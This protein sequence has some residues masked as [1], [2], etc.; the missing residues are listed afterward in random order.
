MGTKIIKYVKEDPN[1]NTAI[2]A[3]TGLT[4]QAVNART[5]ETVNFAELGVT[6]VY[7]ATVGEGWWKVWDDSTGSLTYKGED[8]GIGSFDNLVGDAPAHEVSGS[9]VRFQNPNG[10]WGAWMSVGSGVEFATDAEAIAGTSETA[11]MSPATTNAQIQSKLAYD[12]DTSSYISN[13]LASGAIIE[14]GGNANGEYTKFADGT[15]ICTKIISGSGSFAANEAPVVIGVS[16]S[17]FAHAFVGDIFISKQG[18]LY[19]ANGYEIYGYF[20]EYT[21]QIFFCNT[22]HRPT[23]VHPRWNSIG[24]YTATS[25]NVKILAIGRWK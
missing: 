18:N 1:D 10:T 21:S 4:V 7:K 6:G 13:T 3:H 19:D 16:S 14:R 11:V 22:G 5:G 15:L 23:N 9:T 25:Y 2:L 12:N 17:S 24:S 20:T 8:F